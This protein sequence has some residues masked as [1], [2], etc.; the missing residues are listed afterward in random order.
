MILTAARRFSARALVRN[1]E[2]YAAWADK[3]YGEVVPLPGGERA[4]DYTVRDPAR[5]IWATKVPID[6]V[7]SPQVSAGSLRPAR[8]IYW[9]DRPM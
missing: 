6:N 5:S 2:H 7:G 8:T 9:T 4:L 1:L 3:L